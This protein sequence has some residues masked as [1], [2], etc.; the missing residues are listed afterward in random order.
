MPSLNPFQQ[1]SLEIIL[2]KN[3]S[4]LLEICDNKEG[5]YRYSTPYFIELKNTIH[6][7]AGD[8]ETSDEEMYTIIKKAYETYDASANPTNTRTIDF[9]EITIDMVVRSSYCETG[10]IFTRNKVSKHESFY[11]QVLFLLM[12]LYMKRKGI[13][14]QDYFTKTIGYQK[15]RV[16][17]RDHLVKKMNEQGGDCQTLF[18]KLLDVY[19]FVY[20][21]TNHRLTVRNQ[22]G[23]RRTQYR[24][25]KSKSKSKARKT[26]RS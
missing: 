5:L 9:D 8:T 22:N 12:L 26:R 25:R 4:P 17:L 24:K 15:K 2:D 18:N 21:P 1:N 19:D 14:E 20:P 16:S 11:R 3:I 10:M 23:A 13:Q 6:N 7:F